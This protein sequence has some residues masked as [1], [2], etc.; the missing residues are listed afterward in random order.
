MEE[1]QDLETR[2]VAVPAV[3]VVVAVPAV[4]GCWHR[5]HHFGEGR[6]HGE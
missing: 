3:V 4:V 2:V 6:V 1:N 5:H